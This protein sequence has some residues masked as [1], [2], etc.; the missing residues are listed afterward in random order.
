MAKKVDISE[1]LQFD[2]DPVL[3]INGE[4]IEVNSGAETALKLM[5]IMSGPRTIVNVVNALEIMFGEENTQKICSMTDGAG[6]KL[7]VD[8]LMII[9]EQGI[10]LI[11]G[12]SE[13][14]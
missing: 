6:K 7:K 4:E 1:K 12:T 11:M 5:G 14:E 9:M 2:E 3:V 10:D 13:G 8:S